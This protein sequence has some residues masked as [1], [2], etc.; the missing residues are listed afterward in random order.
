MKL[1]KHT[2][3]TISTCNQNKFGM[4]VVPDPTSH[5]RVPRLIICTAHGIADER[6]KALFLTR[7]GQKMYTKLKVWVSPT[8]IGGLSLDITRLKAQTLPE[9]VE[10]AERYRFFQTATEDG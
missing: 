4:H 10:I 8:S 1:Y 3:I 5:A 7:I 9:M 6:K 2:Q